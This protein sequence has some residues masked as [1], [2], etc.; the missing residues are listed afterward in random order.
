MPLPETFWSG[1]QT[2]LIQHQSFGQYLIL[3]LMVNGLLWNYRPQ[4]RKPVLLS[5]LIFIASLAGLLLSGMLDQLGMSSFAKGL[6]ET[7]VFIMGM[8]GIRLF[9]L[10]LFRLIL[11]LCRVSLLRIL[12]DLAEL[13][14]Y[15]AWI[16]I[17]LHAAGLNLSSILTTSA[18]MTAVL[19]FALQDTLGNI[20]GG[21]ALQLDDSVK[22]G[23]WIKVD[24]VNGR[25]TNIRWRY[26]AIETRNWETVIIP[27]SQLMKGKFSVIGRRQY[28]P[29]LWRRWIYLEVSYQHSIGQVID[30][31]QT[32]IHNGHIVNVAEQ[33][34]ASCV[35]MDFNPSA[36]RYALRYW[37]QDIEADDTTDSEVRS[38]IYAALQRAGIQL[39]YPQFHV[40]LT[41]KDEKHERNKQILR[42]KERM[43]ALQSVDL[44]SPLYDEELAEIAEQLIYTPFVSGDILM[45]QGTLANWLYIIISGSTDIYL[46]LPDNTGRRHVN[47]THGGCLL[48]EMG[49][50]T[51]EPRSA[52]VIAQTD[53]LAYRL[54]KNTFQKILDKRP[55]LAEELSKLLAFRRDSIDNLQQQLE[56]EAMEQLLQ[57]K[58]SSLLRQICHFFGIDWSSR[59]PN[60]S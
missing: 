47:S 55:E 1:Y 7:S 58:Q 14:G 11:P 49:L 59:F 2:F 12:E 39:P 45:R 5:L 50:M 20:L 44:F 19:A 33:P 22:V 16:M 17:H 24:D 3:A 43:D 57:Q 40:H 9:G 53:V 34:A 13:I 46:E 28:Q 30:V 26:T 23:D 60:K 36:A 52:T 25:I 32:A 4:D 37:L 10:F 51:G 6:I 54:D 41:N 31:V 27:N 21:L 18:V 48:G 38:R 56:R 35:L 29:Q 8:A 42:I 15:C